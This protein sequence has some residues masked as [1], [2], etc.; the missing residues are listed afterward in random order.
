M[1]VAGV[2]RDHPG[3]GQTVNGAYLEEIPLDAITPNPDSRGTT[4][5][6]RPLRS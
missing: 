2:N 4:S 1:A 6:R 3:A 5:T